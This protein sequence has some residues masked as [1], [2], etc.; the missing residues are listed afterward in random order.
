MNLGAFFAVVGELDHER[1]LGLVARWRV[2]VGT[3]LIGIGLLGLALLG[4]LGGLLVLPPLGGPRPLVGLATAV[5][6]PVLVP[7]PIPIPATGA[8]V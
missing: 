6:V 7:V 4:L 2:G 3:R 8:L 5:P 1:D